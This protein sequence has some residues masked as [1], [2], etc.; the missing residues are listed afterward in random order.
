MCF[1]VIIRLLKCENNDLLPAIPLS[2]QRKIMTAVR[3]QKKN[4]TAVSSLA[5]RSHS[6][7][8]LDSSQLEPP[9]N[10]AYKLQTGVG[11]R[12][13]KCQIMGDEPSLKPSDYPGA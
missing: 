5:S 1:Y 11:A 8:C 4:M 7:P 10:G 3:G 9:R 12:K 13:K 2:P 6:R